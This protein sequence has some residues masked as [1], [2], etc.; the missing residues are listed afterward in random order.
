MFVNTR[1]DV[2]ADVAVHLLLARS[3]AEAGVRVTFTINEQA[4]GAD[5]MVAA[6]QDVPGV[7]PILCP[8]G[9]PLIGLGRS[10][11][12]R[13]GIGSLKSIPSLAYL[14]QIIVRRH[15]DILH[16]T[17]RPRD[18]F[19]CAALGALTRRP[20][21]IHIH[22]NYA[23]GGR[24]ERWALANCSCLLGISHFTS[25]SMMAAGFSAE[26]VATVLNSIDLRRFDPDGPTGHARERWNVPP[27]APLIGLIGRL[28]RY[29]GHED[30]L[31]AVASEPRL[32]SSHI[33]IVGADTG[34]VLPYV[35]ELR[36]QVERLGL[37]SRVHF[38]GQQDVLS[39]YPDL[40]VLAVP[41][42]EEPFGL[43]VLEA[44]AMRVPVVAYQ[45]GGIPEII[46][47]GTD[48]L[49]VPPRDI[50]A[51]GEALHVIIIDRDFRVRLGRASRARVLEQFSPARQA[52]EMMALYERLCAKKGAIQYGASTP[53]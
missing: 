45:A 39:I 20:S 26:R 7:D 47:S 2:G 8:L 12:L 30:L 48:G 43:V 51:L 14:V 18:A 4:T 1:D 38:T 36:A 28:I 41:S 19:T 3:L 34:Q 22:A 5:K 29:K 9:R 23:P 6:L 13:R 40:D 42:W 53:H 46:R 32:S 17:D 24:M 52:A 31:D 50:R 15:V 27:D 11:R 21:V 37:G 35:K 33:L 49:L 25:R 16:A 44:M 10:E